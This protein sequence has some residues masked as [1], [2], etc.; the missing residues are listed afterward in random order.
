MDWS[1]IYVLMMKVNPWTEQ[2]H[3]VIH[4]MELT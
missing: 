3:L 4:E 2:N 1:S